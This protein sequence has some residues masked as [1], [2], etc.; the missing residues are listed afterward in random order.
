MMLNANPLL[1]L[2]MVI[3][4]SLREEREDFIGVTTRET[5]EF[6]DTLG[7]GFLE[8][9]KKDNAVNITLLDSV[10]QLFDSIPKIFSH[11]GRNMSPSSF[12]H[13]A[14]EGAKNRINEKVTK[15]I[16]N[17]ISK[18]TFIT[19]PLGSIPNRSSSL[20]P[21]VLSQLAR[22]IPSVFAAFSNCNFNS[23]VIRILNCGACPSP[24]GLLS[25]LI[26]DK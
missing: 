19:H 4:T 9:I 13:G 6:S 12:P 8:S 14:K 16:T 15:T 2:K 11:T 25:R 22:L 20:R 10:V 3:S 21:N 18:N 24:L 26:I 17:K 1:K 7:G 5:I 23:G